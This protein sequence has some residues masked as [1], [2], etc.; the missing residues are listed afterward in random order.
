VISL[1]F[2]NEDDLHEVKLPRKKVITLEGKNQ[3]GPI[4]SIRMLNETHQLLHLYPVPEAQS[5]HKNQ[6][7]CDSNGFNST[8][9]VRNYAENQ[10]G[11]T[12][13]KHCQLFVT[14]AQ[15]RIITYQIMLFCP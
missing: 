2:R 4:K 6:H 7:S 11:K 10:R 1:G 14:R 13:N 8:N 15:T 5:E 12:C 3:T 9:Y